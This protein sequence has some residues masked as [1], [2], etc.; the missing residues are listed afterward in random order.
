MC[1]RCVKCIKTSPILY[2][3][4]R[5]DGSLCGQHITEADF[6]VTSKLQNQFEINFFFSNILKHIVLQKSNEMVTT[7]ASDRMNWFVLTGDSVGYIKIWDIRHY[8]DGDDVIENKKAQD[9]MQGQ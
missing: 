3:P 1:Y 9:K 7:M 2:Q 5:L 8:C 6:L 4:V